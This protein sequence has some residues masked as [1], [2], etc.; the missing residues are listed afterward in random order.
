MARALEQHHARVR[1]TKLEPG[2]GAQLQLGPLLRCTFSLA[3]TL[4]DELTAM[5]TSTTF[6]NTTGSRQSLNTLAAALASVTGAAAE[7]GFAIGEN[8][9]PGKTQGSLP[10]PADNTSWKALCGQAL[11]R[12]EEHLHDAA[13]QLELASISC[14]HIAGD[15]E[16]HS[17][18]AQRRTG[19][20]RTPALASTAAASAS[21]T[22]RTR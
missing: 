9:H 12:M 17:A 11:P 7:L 18:P 4:M 1:D 10:N 14:H 5:S 19:A 2:L 21:S 20:A 22:A 3:E 6:T 15:I 8:A 16:L 13:H